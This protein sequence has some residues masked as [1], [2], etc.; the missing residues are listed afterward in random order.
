[1]I[2]AIWPLSARQEGI[3]NDYE[4][5]L[6]FSAPLNE[7]KVPTFVIH[8]DEDINVD[9]IH[10]TKLIKKINGAIYSKGRSSLYELNSCRRNRPFD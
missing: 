1:L 6:N 7:I 10:A 4:Q 5:F 9:I 3:K 2:S 8:G